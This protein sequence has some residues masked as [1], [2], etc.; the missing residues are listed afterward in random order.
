MFAVLLYRS[1]WVTL[2]VL[3]PIDVLGN[4]RDAGGQLTLDPGGHVGAA[5]VEEDLGPVPAAASMEGEKPAAKSGWSE[6]IRSQSLPTIAG[7]SNQPLQTRM[8]TSA[9][10]SYAFRRRSLR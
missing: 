8:Q 9:S 4:S 10:W 5:L 7:L 6:T 1:Q 3:N 2:K